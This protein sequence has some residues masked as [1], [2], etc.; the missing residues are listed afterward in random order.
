V[1]E[2]NHPHSHGPMLIPQGIG[3]GDAWTCADGARHFICYACRHVFTSNP[4]FTEADRTQ[5]MTKLG[6]APK[7][8]DE[9]VFSVCDD[10]HPI[11]LAHL[12]A[13]GVLP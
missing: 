11:V 3:P 1:A 13:K 4:E 12:R 5:E 9:G 10:C 7:E 2:Q 8:P 6:A